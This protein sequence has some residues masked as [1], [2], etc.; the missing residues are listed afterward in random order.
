MKCV[1]CRIGETDVI[2]SRKGKGNNEVWRRRKC[3][4]CEEVFTTSETFSYDSLFVVK[5]NLSRKRFVYEKLFASI[6][7]ALSGG[8]GS[9][10]G[11]DAVKAK[12][13]ARRVIE[14]LFLLN[15]KYVSTK[16]IIRASYEELGKEH[17]FF[18]RKYAMY[19]EYRMK[20]V[21][22]KK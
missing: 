11:D 20:T 3:A 8:K 13:V 19:S 7:V 12:G 15:S 18:A 6:L 1:Y 9:D 14:Q 5:R 17:E 10:M 22:G 21:Q 2:N 16:D 4:K